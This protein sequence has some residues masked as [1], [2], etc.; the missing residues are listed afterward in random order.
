[1]SRR[2]GAARDSLF[3]EDASATFRNP[4]RA[5]KNSAMTEASKRL[6]PCALCRELRVLRDSHLMPQWAYKR[7]QQ[8]CRPGDHPVLVTGGA[9]LMTS[10]QV[11]RHLLCDACEERFHLREDVA[12]RLTELDNGRPRI[13]EHLSPT[14]VGDRKVSPLEAGIAEPLAYFAASILW[15]S[16][17]MNDGCQLG[18]YAEQF[19]GYLLEQAPFPPNAVVSLA[20]L[21]PSGH[22]EN[23]YTPVTFPKSLRA[24]DAWLH[25]FMVCGLAF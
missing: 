5:I 19:R 11:S 22:G 21:E 14:R 6:A 1:M 23:P 7:I 8:V 2:S 10:K 15:R 16:C 17:V 13:F 4:R 24:D 18:P 20:V 12:A 25:G 9:A 3:C